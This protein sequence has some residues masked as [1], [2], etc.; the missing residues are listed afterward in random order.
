V[1]DVRDLR[2]QLAAARDWMRCH[3]AELMG[4]VGAAVLAQL[5]GRST[6]TGDVVHS[7]PVAVP[8]RAAVLPP[9]RELEREAG[10]EGP[11]PVAVSV[12][13][14]T[15][16][17]SVGLAP[18]P[19]P[20]WL[21]RPSSQ[22]RPTRRAMP[23][24]LGAVTGPLLR[25]DQHVAGATGTSPLSGR[26]GMRWVVPAPA[27]PTTGSSV[28]IAIP[29]DAIPAVT[30]PQAPPGLI[31]KHNAGYLGMTGARALRIIRAM[32][33]DARFAPVVIRHG[34]SFRAAPLEAILEY[35]RTA[36]AAA[37]TEDEDEDL[38]LELMRDVGY[39]LAPRAGAR[40]AR[41]A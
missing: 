1:I 14:S 29:L 40:R 5:M 7:H 22:A 32:S 35:L 11:L 16:A 41:G 33:A 23:R 13:P 36:P 3:K 27:V 38:D 26:E 10:D 12:P 39:E 20:P 17:A 28:T 25:A 30:F 24:S 19:A 15:S 37:A 31:T 18:R 21:P 4:P 8:G 2:D 6:A 9:H 34:K